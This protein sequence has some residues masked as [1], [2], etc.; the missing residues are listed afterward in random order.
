MYRITVGFICFNS[1]YPFLG[2]G[3]VHYAFYVS[4]SDTADD[5]SGTSDE[6]RCAAD[7]DV[8]M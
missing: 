2:H 4:Q 5:I 7:A 6:V 3:L 1:I 8:D